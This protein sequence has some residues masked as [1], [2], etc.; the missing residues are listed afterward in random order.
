MG[1]YIS[2]ADTI[3]KQNPVFDFPITIFPGKTVCEN[4]ESDNQQKIFEIFLMHGLILLPSA[5][6]DSAGFQPALSMQIWGNRLLIFDNN[7]L[8]QLYFS[9]WSMLLP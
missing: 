6:A 9:V 3:S 1:V 4:S 2:C 5:E 8:P 7:L